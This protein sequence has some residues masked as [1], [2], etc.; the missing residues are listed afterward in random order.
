MLTGVACYVGVL[1]APADATKLLVFAGAPG[2]VAQSLAGS[3]GWYVFF[4]SLLGA[5]GSF[6]AGS[7]TVSNVL[8]IPLHAD[9]AV[10]NGL[11]Q[12]VVFA[13]QSIG[14]G[15]GNIIAIH[16]VLAV[17]AVVH[18]RSGM[19]K[20]LRVNAVLALA[21]CVVGSLLVFVLA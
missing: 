10:L 11:S 18:L 4:A 16:N 15:A 6:I 21:L 1:V 12:P 17:L 9:A 8:F 14:A 3:G 5:F 20:V 13:A 2:I 7:A 19:R